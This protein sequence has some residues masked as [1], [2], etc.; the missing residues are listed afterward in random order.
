VRGGNPV[1]FV[2]VASLVSG[3]YWNL[4]VRSPWLLVVAIAAQ[5]TTTTSMCH[6]LLECFRVGRV[7]L[8]KRPCYFPRMCVCK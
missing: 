1:L 5:Y 2:T 8:A 7:W 3:L 6:W 4:L